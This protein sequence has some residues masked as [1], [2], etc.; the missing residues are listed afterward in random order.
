MTYEDV[1]VFRG[2]CP[3]CGLFQNKIIPMCKD[4]GCLVL[5]FYKNVKC[6]CG[7]ILWKGNMR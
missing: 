2:S 1:E 3:K 6:K 5:H 7:K 4:A